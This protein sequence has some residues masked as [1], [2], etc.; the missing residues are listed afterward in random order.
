VVIYGQWRIPLQIV[1]SAIQNHIRHLTTC[2][3]EAE[4]LM[5]FPYYFEPD[6]LLIESDTIP[7]SSVRDATDH[8]QDLEMV[9]REYRYKDCQDPRDKVYGI[10]GLVDRSMYQALRPDY[11][12][13]IREVYTGAMKAI[14]SKHTDGLRFLTGQGFNSSQHDLPSWV[15][16]FSHRPNISVLRHE[17]NIMQAYNLY[18][19]SPFTTNQVF[20]ENDSYLHLKG[21]KIDIV[22]KVGTALNTLDWRIVGSV[23]ES[24][25]H[26]AGI[27]ILEVPWAH[28]RQ[29]SFWRTILAD[30]VYEVEKKQ[31]RRCNDHDISE[32]HSWLIRSLVMFKIGLQPPL[33]D[34][35]VLAFLAAIYG[36]AIFVT[37]RGHIGLSYDK[38]EEGDEI[39]ALHGGLVPFILRNQ[40]GGPDDFRAMVGDCYLDG[41]MDGEAYDKPREVRRVVLN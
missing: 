27:R 1:K 17:M 25:H 18:R 15:R 23:L 32:F 10:L 7:G 41:Y 38:M 16:D 24:W 28:Q 26:I 35:F 36:R 39:W 22:A 6:R 21:V 9:L 4:K 33:K 12:V 37:N 30:T 14:I 40:Q 34:C 5:G 2:C 8:V 3:S 29:R 20:I 11:S 19:C 31:L 13:S